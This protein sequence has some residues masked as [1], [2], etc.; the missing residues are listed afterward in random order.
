ME[1]EATGYLIPDKV[2]DVLI[3]LV[4]SLSYGR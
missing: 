3:S 1:E 2:Y 4:G